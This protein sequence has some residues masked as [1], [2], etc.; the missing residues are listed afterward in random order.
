MR[1]ARADRTDWPKN[2]FLFAE[3][4]DR[5]SERLLDISQRFER[6]LDLGCHD[7]AFGTLLLAQGC[8]SE[9]VSTDISEDLMGRQTSGMRIVADE[10]FLPFAPNSFDLIGS[11]LSLH[12]TNDLPGALIQLTRCLRPNGLFLGALFGIETLGELK[13]CLMQ[14]ELEIKGG[15]SPRISPFTDVRD[16]GSLLQRAGFALPVT[17]VDLLTLKYKNAFDLMQELRGMGEANALNE[18]M[19]TFTGR[20]ILF[21]AAEL[22]QE[23]YQD[24]DGLIRATFQIIYLAGWSPHDSQQKPLRPGSGQTSL[25]DILSQDDQS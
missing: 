15:V 1:R 21:R 17:D 8:V 12:W 2:R 7:G 5:L 13:D 22:Y 25:Q 10:E 9:L 6:A 24:E 11:V 19:K 14:A 20:K 23:K 16:A 3:V 18:R 4:S